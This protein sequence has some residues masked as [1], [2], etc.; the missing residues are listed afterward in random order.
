MSDL[1]EALEFYADPDNYDDFIARPPGRDSY[2]HSAHVKLDKGER[3]RQALL[4]P[5]PDGATEEHRIVK[6]ARHRVDIGMGRANYFSP[7]KVIAAYEAGLAASPSVSPVRPKGEEGWVASYDKRAD[8]MYIARREEP[9]WRASEGTATVVRRLT[10]DGT[11]IGVTILD[12][13]EIAPSQPTQTGEENAELVE[14]IETAK[15]A[16]EWIARD[17]DYDPR[18]IMRRLINAASRSPIP[19]EADS[20]ASLGARS[21]AQRPRG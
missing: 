1:R 4:P 10:S 9:A 21:L 15:E 3:A 17:P 19:G 11:L 12:F 8:V 6:A 13:S 20:A 16:I 7:L 18:P 5:A 2:F 14:L